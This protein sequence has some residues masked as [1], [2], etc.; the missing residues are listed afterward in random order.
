MKYFTFTVHK[1]NGNT[2]QFT[3]ASKRSLKEVVKRLGFDYLSES[4]DEY[5]NKVF[6]GLGTRTGFTLTL[7]E[8]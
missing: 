3:M 5:G 4:K 8:L 1:P 7:I 6:I 2:S